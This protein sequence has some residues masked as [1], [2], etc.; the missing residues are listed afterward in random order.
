MSTKRLNASERAT[1]FSDLP[2]AGSSKMSRAILTRSARLPQSCVG[3]NIGWMTTS[4]GSSRRKPAT[5][6]ASPSPRHS[7]WTNA[8][9]RTLRRRAEIPPMILLIPTSPFSRSALELSPPRACNAQLEQLRLNGRGPVP[10]GF[11]RQGPR[12]HAGSAAIPVANTSTAFHPKR[13]ENCRLAINFLSFRVPAKAVDARRVCPR[14]NRIEAPCRG[15]TN[16][17]TEP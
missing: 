3:W 12:I 17:R 13:E 15:V 9:F 6:S 16:E 4:F 14:P 7:S 11:R 2:C 10:L 8:S 5:L 1:Y